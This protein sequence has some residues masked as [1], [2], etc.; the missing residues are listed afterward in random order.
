MTDASMFEDPPEAAAEQVEPISDTVTVRTMGMPFVDTFTFGD[1]VI[2]R[3]GTS[4]PRAQLE[5]LLQGARNVNVHLE[6]VA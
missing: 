4:V 1:F 3:L 2:T 6:V 5:D